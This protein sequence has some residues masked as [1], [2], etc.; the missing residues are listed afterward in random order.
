MA[1]E[2][3]TEKSSEFQ[4]ALGESDVWAEPRGAKWNKP[5]KMVA[6]VWFPLK[7]QHMWRLLVQQL[8]VEPL[9][10]AEQAFWALGPQLREKKQSNSSFVK[11]TFKKAEGGEREEQREEEVWRVFKDMKCPGLGPRNPLWL[12]LD[13]P[14]V[15][16]RLV[17]S[18][19][20]R[21]WF[22]VVGWDS[23]KGVELGWVGVV[24]LRWSE[25][26]SARQES[27]AEF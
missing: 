24:I 13:F 19:S 14:P 12:L 17:H 6:E 9:P 15:E 7:T 3:L 2:S 4:R 27:A 8:F 5:D 20:L 21:T 16:Q 1:W 18:K 25:L 11:S 10:W 26:T 22:A 23:A